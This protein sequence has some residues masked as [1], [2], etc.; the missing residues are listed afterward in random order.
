MTADESPLS[1]LI[2]KNNQIM[3]EMLDAQEKWLQAQQKLLS[4]LKDR[5]DD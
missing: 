1:G 2:D 5:E 4:D 3:Q